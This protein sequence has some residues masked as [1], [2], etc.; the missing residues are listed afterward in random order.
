MY[1]VLITLYIFYN[2]MKLTEIIK[3]AQDKHEACETI[4]K[5]LQLKE[6]RD[7]L[8][9]KEEQLE[10]L[11]SDF[12]EALNKEEKEIQTYVK[13]MTDE[14]YEKLGGENDCSDTSTLSVG[15]LTWS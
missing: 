8:E 9:E 4:K 14:D 10:S 6:L 12:K 1:T 3:Q 2:K 11:K 13:T 15:S 7:N 5:I